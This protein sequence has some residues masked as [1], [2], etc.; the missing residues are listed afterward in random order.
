[1]SLVG[2]TSCGGSRPDIVAKSA[3]IRAQERVGIRTA[4]ATCI[5][6][7][8]SVELSRDELRAFVSNPAN[9]PPVLSQRV[10]KL[11]ADCAVEVAPTPS[12]SAPSTSAPSASTTTGH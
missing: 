12:A 5:A 10:T 8:A 11:A 9:L 2:L 1:M 6:N 7:A 4:L 3:L